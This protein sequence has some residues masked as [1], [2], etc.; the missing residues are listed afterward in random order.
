MRT[1]L[2]ASCAVLLVSFSLEA[3]K[4]IKMPAAQQT[5]SAKQHRA[6]IK[7][8]QKTRKVKHHQRVN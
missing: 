2:V 8:I 1:L 3:K 5:A 7:K 4:K 6:E